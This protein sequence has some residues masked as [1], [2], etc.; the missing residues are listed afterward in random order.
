MKINS[1]L[2]TAIAAL[3]VLS[4]VTF[5][6][7][8]FQSLNLQANTEKMVT[9][10]QVLLMGI[11]EMYAMGLQTGQA[12]RNILI[13][14][15]D[16]QAN[17][18]Y[19]QAHEEFKKNNNNAITL[20][21]GEMKEKM[22]K[23]GELWDKDHAIKSAVIQHSISGKQD[24]AISLLNKTETPLWREVKSNLLEVQKKQE[25]A[26]HIRLGEVRRSIQTLKILNVSNLLLIIL[27]LT[28]I[29]LMFQKKI[30]KPI[31]RV[32]E[33]LAE[34]ANQVAMES[35]QI[36]SESQSLAEGASEQAAGFEE[37]SSS[38]EEMSSMTKQSA[39]N[40]N[41][42]N[43]LMSETNRVVNQAN[44]SMDQ[45]TTSMSDISKASSETFKI[46]KTID[47]I[48][49]QT[50]LLALN[51][52]VEAARAG[53]AGAGFA[54]VADEVRNL[55]MRA[56]D[57]AKNTSSMIEETVKKVKDGSL[58]VTQ[59]NEAFQQVTASSGKVAGLVGEIAAAS[60]EQA[61]GIAQVNMAVLEMDKVTQQNAAS[62]EE[63]ASA[64]E[65]LNSQSEQM[66]IIV[67]ELLVMV[68]KNA[69]LPTGGHGSGSRPRTA[70]HARQVPQKAL[71]V[72]KKTAKG[73]SLTLHRSKEV[74]PDDIIPMNENDFKDF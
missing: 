59:A 60:G 35:S 47:E 21:N 48:A 71:A 9:M 46:I 19:L 61:Q 50:N 63:S 30:I 66:K 27:M 22:L 49:F 68:G 72:V 37:T 15:K 16:E 26:S 55:A 31:T 65:E 56:A 18:N 32:A 12:T 41:H 57:A 62:A 2:G 24:E 23:I 70:V 17:K 29:W 69:A 74:H 39:E 44:A 11:S 13:N 51:A 38:L 36:S 64:C 7:L 43:S 73:R 3:L 14:P 58:L 54:V 67:D 5:S 42:A 40:A 53:E 10:D 1:M 6:I 4:I 33:G 8:H 34:T 52:A 20:S 45:L 28:G 25:E